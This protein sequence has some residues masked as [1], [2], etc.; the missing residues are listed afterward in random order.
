MNNTEN[1][2]RKNRNSQKSIADY[3]KKHYKQIN[4]SVAADKKEI[5]LAHAEK[6]QDEVGEPRTK[7]YSPKGSVNAFINRAIDETMERDI[8][9]GDGE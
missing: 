6:Y 3:K 1:S 4:V 8:K 7:G 9:A 5:I 2:T